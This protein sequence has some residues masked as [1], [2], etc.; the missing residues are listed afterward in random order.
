MFAVVFVWAWALADL[1]GS[2]KAANSVAAIATDGVSRILRLSMDYPD[3]K[4][5]AVCSSARQMD[6]VSTVILWLH[7]RLLDK[8]ATKAGS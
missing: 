8:L 3:A 1:T 6:T 7:G 5:L 4:S 2:A